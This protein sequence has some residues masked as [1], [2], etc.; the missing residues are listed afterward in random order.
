MV[1]QKTGVDVLNVK[2]RKGVPLTEESPLPPKDK[3][4]TAMTSI[5]HRPGVGRG[6]FTTTDCV[7]LR[8]GARKTTKWCHARCDMECLLENWGW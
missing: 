3:T 7:S 6:G 8:H 4:A 2:F 5:P 1:L